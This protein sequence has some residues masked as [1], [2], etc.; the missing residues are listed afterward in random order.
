MAKSNDFEDFEQT[1]RRL[2]QVG[3]L[4]SFRTPAIERISD[5]FAALPSLHLVWATWCAFALY[6]A[7]AYRRWLRAAVI[8]YPVVTAAVV[9]VTANHYLLDV[10]AGVAVAAI[11]LYVATALIG[12]SRRRLAVVPVAIPD[13]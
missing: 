9:I 12:A 2:Q 6:P 13:G 1:V 3:G 11:G 7:V 8:G 5:P 10:I 4:W